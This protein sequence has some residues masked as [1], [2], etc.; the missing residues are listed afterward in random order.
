VLL[1][2]NHGGGVSVFAAALGVGDR[3]GSLQAGKQADIILLDSSHWEHL[4]YE[5]GDGTRILDVFRL[6][7]SVQ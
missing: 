3:V 4:I 1:C 7:V 2:F 5:M 6:G